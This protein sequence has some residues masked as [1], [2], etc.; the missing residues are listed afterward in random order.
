MEW[1][2]RPS[3]FQE[4]R[5]SVERLIESVRP[6]RSEHLGTCLNDP[7]AF[8]FLRGFLVVA[9]CAGGRTLPT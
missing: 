9:R 7:P 8:A 2:R 4:V 5:C 3:R 6:G 1:Q